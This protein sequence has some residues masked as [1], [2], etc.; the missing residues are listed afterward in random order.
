MGP[1][2]L[3]GA[4][5]NCSHGGWGKILIPRPGIRRGE[6]RPARPAT[7]AG[8]LPPLSRSSTP[9][10][11]PSG[12]FRPGF[13]PRFRAN[14]EADVVGLDDGL[15]VARTDEVVEGCARCARHEIIVLGH[16]VEDWKGD[17]AEIDGLYQGPDRWDASK[18]SAQAHSA[19]RDRGCHLLHDLK[20][21][22]KRFVVGGCRV[23]TRGLNHNT[24]STSHLILAWS[25]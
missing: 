1:G 22:R 4:S 13:L 16:D 3:A 15:A 24:N 23:E 17:F 11:Q 9:F 14:G 25:R 20:F 8:P 7:T 6:F 2:A 18:L 5:G 21:S 12:G 19:R 10:G